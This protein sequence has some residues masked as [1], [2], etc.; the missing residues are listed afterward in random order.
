MIIDGF[1]AEQIVSLALLK[2]TVDYLEAL[3]YDTID[4]LK[5]GWINR[6]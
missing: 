3:D 6:N 4:W 2:G 1:T 5:W